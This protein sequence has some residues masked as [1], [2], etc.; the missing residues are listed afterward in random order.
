MRASAFAGD[1][2]HVAPGVSPTALSTRGTS[3]RSAHA[4][5]RS[6]FGSRP[7]A[8]FPRARRWRSSAPCRPACR[9]TPKESAPFPGAGPY[10]VAEYR[11]GQRVV[12][13]RNRFYGAKH[14]G[15]R[16]HHVDG[17]VVDLT[18]PSPGDVVD[19]IESGQADW[20]DTSR[21]S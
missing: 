8:D 6:S 16:P 21:G 10:Y 13:K 3:P 17:F 11:P 20:G 15:T 18:A 12:I 19:R 5:S 2:A 4:D 9:P 7:V 1:P 14:G